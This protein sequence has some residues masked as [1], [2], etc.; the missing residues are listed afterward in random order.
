[1]MVVSAP[2][3]E[4][5]QPR[6][7]DFMWP[8]SVDESF[9]TIGCGRVP[10]ASEPK[11]WCEAGGGMVLELMW[12]FFDQRVLLHVR[13]RPG[14]LGWETEVLVQRVRETTRSAEGKLT[15]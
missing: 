7:P 2:A 3:H 1:M 11:Y 10:P 13:L 6:M 5:L 9:S 14:S 8:A 15:A 4:P 12:H